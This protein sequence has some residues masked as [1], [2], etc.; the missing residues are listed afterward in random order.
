[1][2]W[3]DL[4]CGTGAVAELAAQAG[5]DVTGVDLAPALIETAKERAERARTRDRLPRRRLREPRVRG[6]A[7]S[8]SCRR[9]AASMFSPDHE[10]TARELARVV[11][12]GGRIGLANWTPPRRAWRRSFR[13]M[14]PF[15]PPPPEGVGYPFDW[16]ERAARQG[17]PRGCFELELERHISPLRLPTG[18]AYWRALL[19]ELRADARRSP[20]RSTTSSARSSI[21]T[22]STSSRPSYRRRRDRARPRVAAR[23][24]DA[25]LSA[26]VSLRDEVTELLQELIRL[27]T[28]NPPGNETRAAGAPP[29]LPRGERRRLRALRQGAGARQ[30]RRADSRLGRRAA[31]R[32]PLAHGHGARRSGGVEGRSLVGRAPRRRD[33]GPR[34]ARHEGA[35]RGERRGDGVARA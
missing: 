11:K 3:L 21:A 7:P 1:M 22:G 35:G 6:R 27:D 34:R 5:A 31:A 32:A 16:G 20:S 29:G 17:A 23:V 2:K 15:Q 26:T 9:R 25:P 33:L 13:M 14:K 18:E 19:V 10:A 12:P 24:R 28:V 4:A 30:P 8:T